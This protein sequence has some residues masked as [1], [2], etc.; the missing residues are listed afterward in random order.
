MRRSEGGQVVDL[1]LERRRWA[2]VHPSSEVARHSGSVLGEVVDLAVLVASAV[3]SARQLASV[4]D[5][6]V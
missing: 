1:G 4:T 6:T 2:E 3:V 5:A